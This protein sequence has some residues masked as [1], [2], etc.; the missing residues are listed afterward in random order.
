M[1]EEEKHVTGVNK[2][3]KQYE[4]VWLFT[5]E[6][7][8]EKVCYKKRG[9][10]TTSRGQIPQANIFCIPRQL[11]CFLK[12]WKLSPPLSDISNRTCCIPIWQEIFARKSEGRHWE[13]PYKI[14]PRIPVQKCAMNLCFC[15]PLLCAYVAMQHF[16]NEVL[17]FENIRQIKRSWWLVRGV[18]VH[19]LRN[20]EVFP[21]QLFQK[22]GMFNEATWSL[23]ST[24]SR[25]TSLWFS[26]SE[27]CKALFH[28]PRKQG[29]FSEVLVCGL[30]Q[31]RIFFPTVWWV[32]CNCT[33]QLPSMNSIWAISKVFIVHWTK[34]T[35]KMNE[36]EGASAVFSYAQKRRKVTAWAWQN[37]KGSAKYKQMKSQTLQTPLDHI[38]CASSQSKCSGYLQV[39]TVL[40][41]WASSMNNS[42]YL[43]MIVYINAHTW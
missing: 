28:V 5:T 41:V 34:N 8:K 1:C 43:I 36:V 37:T 29:S 14:S 42:R 35:E 25:Q 13:K 40:V 16:C 21:G 20:R 31:R 2:T 33:C 17:E 39:N 38:F 9:T 27:P 12:W 6:Y 18:A 23:K 10:C 30:W 7:W 15:R 24:S 32:E 19:V 26:E 11:V 3:Q 22:F 4:P